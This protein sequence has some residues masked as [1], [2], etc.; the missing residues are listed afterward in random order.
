MDKSESKEVE[1]TD[2][3]DGTVLEVKVVN[4]PKPQPEK[5]EDDD[6]GYLEIK[7][8]EEDKKDEDFEY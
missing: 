4:Q 3:T 1:D 8:S 2:E 6:D 5:Q 7:L